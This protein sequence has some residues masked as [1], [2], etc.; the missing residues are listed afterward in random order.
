MPDDT[1]ASIPQVP[2]D[3]IDLSDP[4]FWVRDRAYREG[5]FKT[6]RDESPFQFFDERVIENSPFPP[7]P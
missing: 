4:E 2:L 3:T 7:G 5:A 6:L 1:A